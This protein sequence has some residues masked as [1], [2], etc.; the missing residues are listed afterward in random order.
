MDEL[1][2]IETGI[3]LQIKLRIPNAFNVVLSEQNIISLWHAFKE[4][5]RTLLG[6]SMFQR[7]DSLMGF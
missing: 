7:Y 6:N 2:K 4:K 5:R 3:D 1:N